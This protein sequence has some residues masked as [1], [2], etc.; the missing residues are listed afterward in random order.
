[1]NTKIRRSRI[2]KRKKE[3][4]QRK[5]P[6]T[7]N[8]P[9][10]VEDIKAKMQASIEKGDCLSEGK[11]KLINHRKHSSWMTDPQDQ[12]MVV[13]RM[14]PVH[15]FPNPQGSERNRIGSRGS[16]REGQ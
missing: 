14:M 9:S 6:K 10:S 4:K 5:T 11:A 8:G 1:M 12:L 16:E 15:G 13:E 3:R 2:L 7:S